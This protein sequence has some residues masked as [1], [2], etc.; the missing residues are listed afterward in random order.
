MKALAYSFKMFFSQKKGRVYTKQRLPQERTV[1]EI[2]LFFFGKADRVPES[3]ILKR[4]GRMQVLLQKR[5]FALQEIALCCLFQTIAVA[6]K[7]FLSIDGLS[8]LCPFAR[9]KKSKI[10]STIEI[11]QF[12]LLTPESQVPF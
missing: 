11:N 7:Y 1:T 5:I 12:F 4:K 8:V 6:G 9:N 2:I 10:T 3:K